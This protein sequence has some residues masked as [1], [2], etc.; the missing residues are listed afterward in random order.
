MKVKAA[1]LI[2]IQARMSRL[3][4]AVSGIFA[5]IELLFPAG[6]LLV[7]LYILIAD[8]RRGWR[9]DVP[10]GVTS[11]GQFRFSGSDR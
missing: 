7:S 6:V 10:L 11:I 3:N 9:A 4:V 2:E 8:F 1:T 5:W